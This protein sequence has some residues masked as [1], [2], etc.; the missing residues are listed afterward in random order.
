VSERDIA[1]Q[2]SAGPHGRVDAAI[3]HALPRRRCEVD[4]RPE[5]IPVAVRRGQ[6]EIALTDAPRPVGTRAVEEL[7]DVGPLSPALKLRAVVLKPRAE[8]GSDHAV[9]CRHDQVEV[10][11]RLELLAPC[12]HQL[13]HTRALAVVARCEARPL[14]WRGRRVDD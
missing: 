11:L 7:L 4:A 10:I 13:E 9:H 8:V 12:L 1:E 14:C 6:A 5:H 3:L 2:H